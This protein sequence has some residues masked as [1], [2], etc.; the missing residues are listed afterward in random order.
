KSRSGYTGGRPR[1]RVGGAYMGIPSASLTKV[2]SKDSCSNIGDLRTRW[3]GEP[4]CYGGN[5]ARGSAGA[6]QNYEHGS[7]KLIHHPRP[8]S[9]FPFHLPAA[10]V[11]IRYRPPPSAG[12]MLTP[13]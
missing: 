7:T 6:A 11:H 8:L 10:S 2:T 3:L 9:F 1:P 4:L 5:R 12:K 13:F